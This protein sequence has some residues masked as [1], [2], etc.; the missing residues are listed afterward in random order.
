MKTNKEILD[1]L[2][3]TVQMG[4]CGIRC[5]QDSAEGAE[6]RQVLTDQLG[7]YDN[8]ERDAYSLASNRGWELEPLNQGVERMS[9]M[10][11]KMQLMGGQKDSK[12][13]KMLVQGNTRGMIKGLKNL[14]HC[15]KLDPS[16]DDTSGY[17]K[18]LP[19]SQPSIGLVSKS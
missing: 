1:S 4:Q 3:K 17:C 6:L 7:E 18:Y 12:I 11:A 10:M 5:V 14:H 15:G 19:T 13:A 16:V 8:I 9:S 2:L